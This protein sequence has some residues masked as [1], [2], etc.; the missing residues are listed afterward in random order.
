[1]KDFLHLQAG[2]WFTKFLL[3]SLLHKYDGLS[4]VSR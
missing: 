1:M 3:K 4:V 2:E